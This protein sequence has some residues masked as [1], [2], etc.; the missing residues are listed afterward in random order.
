MIDVQLLVVNRTDKNL[1]CGVGE[2]GELFVRAA[3]LAEG[4]L[5][6]PDL[7]REKFIPNWMTASNALEMDHPYEEWHKY[8]LG[9][10][11]RLYRTGDLGRYTPNGDGKMSLLITK[12]MVQSNVLGVPTI[13]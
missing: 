11:D 10:R 4:Y 9:P 2:I 12:L 13:R 6:L 5:Q 8:Y 1:L 7:T 3:G